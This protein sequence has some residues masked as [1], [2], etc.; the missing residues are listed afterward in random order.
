M[1]NYNMTKSRRSFRKK[2]S[3]K[4]LA[5]RILSICEKEKIKIL[6]LTSTNNKCDFQNQ[7]L[8]N[9]YEVFLEKDIKVLV[10]HAVISAEGDMGENVE[11]ANNRCKITTLNNFT[12]KQLSLLLKEN[13]SDYD[14]ILVS[15]PCVLVWSEALEYAKVCKNLI[16]VEKY[17]YS[18]Y[19]DYKNL[20][21]E[22]ENSEVIPRGVV[23]IK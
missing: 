3:Y 14:L 11:S 20:L 15:V 23:A 9:L 7:V 6:G 18:Y 12:A 16:L 22:L 2:E 13:A 4:Y 1:L 8:E 10:V 19:K 5:N 17:M 21:Y